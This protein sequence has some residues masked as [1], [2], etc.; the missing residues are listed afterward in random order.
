ME[1]WVQ[2]N[3]VSMPTRTWWKGARGKTKRVGVAEEQKPG[4]NGEKVGSGGRVLPMV[5][6]RRQRLGRRGLLGV[7]CNA[8]TAR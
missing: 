4:G 7:G 3:A 1:G 2:W 6:G 8:L 5:V